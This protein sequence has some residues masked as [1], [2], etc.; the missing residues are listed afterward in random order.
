LGAGG[1]D[2][3]YERKFPEPVSGRRRRWYV[4]NVEVIVL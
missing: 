3:A 1:G 4:D 2:L